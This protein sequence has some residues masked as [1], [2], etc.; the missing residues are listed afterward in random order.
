MRAWVLPFMYHFSSLVLRAVHSAVR[1]IFVVVSAPHQN[2]R[3]P[4]N[5]SCHH[6]RNGSS[7]TSVAVLV[8][9]VVDVHL[10]ITHTE[11][12]R[13]LNPKN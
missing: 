2:I 7:A 4:K 6:L 1:P 8:G 9:A 13:D 3:F 12:K 5:P 11:K 10:C